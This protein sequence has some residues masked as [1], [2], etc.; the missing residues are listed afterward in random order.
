MCGGR[1]RRRG[2]G[3]DAGAGGRGFCGPALAVVALA[4]AAVVAFL[5]G[6]AGGISY[7]GDGWLHECAKWDAEGGRFLVSTFFGAGVAEVRV[8]AGKEEDALA[9]R[10]FVADPEVS[11]RVALGLAVDATRRRVLVA[12]ADRPPRFGYAAVGA[13]ELGSG[14]RLF[15]V[16]LDGPGESSFADDVAVDE[17]G[18]AYVTDIMGSKIW[19]VSPDGEPLS[20][21]KNGTFTQRAG[22]ANNLIGLNGIVYHPNGYLLVVHTSGGDLFKVDPRTGGVGVVKVRGSLKRGDGLELLSPTRLAVAGMPSRLVESSDD[23]ETASVTGRYVGPA[24]RV[25]S[26]ATVKDGDVYVNHIFGFGLGSKKTHVLAKAVF[27]PL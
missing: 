10:V 19:K 13:Y 7:A 22:T 9:E 14:R 25:G 15:L 27:A 4:A 6:T 20:I 3:S 26:S 23:W 1:R 16:R 24:H 12:Y 8:G 11:G 17:D 2:G 21:I 18:N 5:E